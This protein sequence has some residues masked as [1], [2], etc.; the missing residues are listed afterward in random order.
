MK[1]WKYVKCY[2]VCFEAETLEHHIALIAR[3]KCHKTCRKILGE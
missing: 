2:Q 1:Y 3:V